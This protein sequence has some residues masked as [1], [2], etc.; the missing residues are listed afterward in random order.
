MP[1]TD[2]SSRGTLECV[3]SASL[4]A[5]RA[6]FAGGK[7]YLAAATAGLPPLASVAASRRDLDLSLRGHVDTAAYTAAA[8]DARSAFARLVA[9]SAERVSIGSQTSVFAAMVATAVPDGGEV[10]CPE[11]DFSSIVLPFV[12]AGRGVR[13][14]TAPLRELAAAID[15]RTSLVAFSIVQ[16]ATGEV[17]D[18]D[19]I[20]EAARSAGARTFCDATQA[21]GWLPIEAHRFDALVCH[22]YKWLCAP[23]GAAFLAVSQ[24]L[25]ERMRPIAAGWYAGRDPWS[26]C[27]GADVDLAETAARF[28]VSPAWQTF[29]GAAPAIEL[30]AEADTAQIHDHATGLAR[31]FREGRS[32]PVVDHESA[33]VTWADPAG[34]DLA[35]LDAAGITASGRAGRT[36][37]A[38]HVFNDTADVDRALNALDDRGVA[39]RAKARETVI[40]A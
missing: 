29:L 18:V 8:E 5:V 36:R 35:A 11:G 16:S 24:D 6:A 21:A 27:Y 3:T 7:D 34:S 15:S 12:H 38:F 33:I 20:L 9:V 2:A 23:R 32:L 19:A 1:W 10:L 14:R 13:V 22:A 40:A 17:A 31:R 28:D 39:A 25:Q 26:S 30:F 4:T 37:V